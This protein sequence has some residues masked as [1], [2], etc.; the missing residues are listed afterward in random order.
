M[1]H[2]D[3]PPQHA[4]DNPGT[5]RAAAL[6][7]F[8]SRQSLFAAVDPADPDARRLWRACE[9]CTYLEHRFSGVPDPRGLS[10]PEIAAWE[11]LGLSDG[12]RAGDPRALGD[13]RPYWVTL[14]G[15]LLGTVAVAVRDRGWGLPALWVA[16]L[17][18]FREHRHQ[19]YAT[20]IM[21]VLEGAA[22]HLGF[23]ALRLE[24]YWPWQ[25]P[26]RL[27][28]R[29][30]FWVAN[31]KHNLSLVRHFDDPPY[32]VLTDGERMG[33]MLGKAADAEA[34]IMAGRHG[35]RLLWE[36][37][38]PAPARPDGGR[39]TW[40]MPAPTLALWLAVAGWPL[41]R[42]P[43]EWEHRYH[44]YDTGMPEG[45]AYKITVFE[46]YARYHGYRVDTPRIPGLV[47]PDW[48]EF[49]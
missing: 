32:Q 1:A 41:I 9:L 15:R 11:R 18:V 43:A 19:G 44:W 13:Y 7:S 28:L 2:S 8:L 23:G 12:E 36:E 35:D 33:F 14:D 3:P 26:V 16:S 6:E 48:E 31:W 5:D 20:L 45:L 24:T 17:Y 21:A 47:Y 25:G 37:H 42:G 4:D 38:S 39:E 22:R 27:Y 40:A 30:G 46:A 10:D 29:L 49:R 34:L